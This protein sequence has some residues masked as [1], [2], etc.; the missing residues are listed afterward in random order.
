MNEQDPSTTQADHLEIVLGKLNEIAKIAARD[1]YIYRG[2]PEHY[3]R[4]SSGLYRQYSKIQGEDFDIEAVQEEMLSDAT[5][6]TGQTDE[7]EILTFIQHYGGKTNLIDFTADFNV[8]AFFACGSPHDKNGRIVFLKRHHADSDICIMKPWTPKHRVIAQKSIFVQP[9][10]G[11][12]EPHNEINIPK[13]LKQPLLA[14]LRTRHG[15]ESKEIYQDLHGYIQQ[16]DSTSDTPSTPVRLTPEQEDLCRRMDELHALD[17][18]KTKPSDMFRGA[19]SA[20][21]DEN[22]PDRIAQA[23][24]SLREIL[25]PIIG[26]RKQAFEKYGSVFLNVGF[27]EILRDLN[28]LVHHGVNSDR[29]DFQNFSAS[30]FDN[31]MKDFEATMQTAL[32]RPID[33]HRNIGQ[34]LNGDLPG[35]LID[36]E[37]QK[38]QIRSSQ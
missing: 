17:Q 3:E 24:L 18:L 1:D 31:L 34:F 13:E 7:F 9:K 2:E 32:I 35:D 15:I 14:H 5:K 23:A 37:K 29:L 6:Y 19:L 21:R 22:N 28:D 25:L 26:A 8:A 38:W 12:V 27:G 11:Y 16:Q 4:V 30:D 33:V 36:S 20:M 10:K